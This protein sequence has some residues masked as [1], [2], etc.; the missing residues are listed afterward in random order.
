MKKYNY[1]VLFL[2][3]ITL[4]SFCI[5]C[6][7]QADEGASNQDARAVDP[8]EGVWELTSHYW[9]L[10][11]DT[12]YADEVAVQ[13][14]IYFDGYVMWT[15]D[16]APDSSEWHGYGTYHLSNDTLIEKLLSMSLPLKL[17]MGSEDEAMLKIEYDHNFYKQELE[18]TFRDTVYLSIEEWKKL[19]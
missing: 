7:Q 17:A 11:D 5:A 6:N 16:P 15:S 13:H 4:F 3:T 8:V 2:L 19:N 10:D 18:Q 14:K 12:I 1:A 9:V